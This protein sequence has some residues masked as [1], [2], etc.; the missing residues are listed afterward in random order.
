[1]IPLGRPERT[2]SSAARPPWMSC[3]RPQQSLQV[4]SPNKEIE[5]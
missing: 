3:L 2:G 4:L 1:M 5:K